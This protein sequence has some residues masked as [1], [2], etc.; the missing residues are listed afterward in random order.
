MSY[1]TY[2]L[3]HLISLILIAACFG[4][5]FI[6]SDDSK[7]VKKW[8]KILSMV[9]ATF[10]FVA[11]MGLIARTLPG[12]SWPLWLKL[13]LIIWGILVTLGPIVLKRFKQH[14]KPVFFVMIGL[15][16]MAVSLVIFK[17]L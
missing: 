12:Q 4:I 9:A 13:K 10:L 5:N 17:P 7:N 14:R 8:P 11:G 1:E 6:S 2:K 15:L 3:I 16:I